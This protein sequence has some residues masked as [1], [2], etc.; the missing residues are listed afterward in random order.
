M[1]Q[2]KLVGEK[3]A[4]FIEDN[5]VVG[6]GTGSTATYMVE[7][8]AQRVKNENLT[9][10]CVS[11]SN[12][13][14]DLAIDLG[15]KVKELSE[16]GEIDLTIDGSD[17]ISPDYQGIKG[18]GGALLY[19]KIVAVNSKKVIWIVDNSKMVEH[20]GAFPL[21]VEVIPFGSEHLFEKFKQKGYKPTYRMQDAVDKF[22]TDAGNIIIDLQ[23]DKI[24]NPKQMARELES[25]AG[26]VEHGFFLDM[27]DQVIVG[28]ENGEVEILTV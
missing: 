8:L 10:T 25:E 27:V 22:V 6:L 24:E 12:V 20:L 5:T 28:H 1:N 16:V 14:R 17:E 15:L 4:T 21:P 26:V 9:V 23:L 11:T 7:A 18:G 13:T 3:A 2:K 19:E